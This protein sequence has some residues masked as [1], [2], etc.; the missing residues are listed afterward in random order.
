[1][2]WEHSSLVLGGP[3]IQRGAPWPV[4]ACF[5]SAFLIWQAAA[6]GWCGEFAF[7]HHFIDR[8]LPGASYGQSCLVD[9]DK[10][11]DLDFI[12]GGKDEQKSVYWFE[13]RAPGDWVRHLLGANHPSDVGGTALDVDGDGWFDHVAG[14]VWYRNTGKPRNEPFERIVFDAELTAVHDLVAAD[15]DGDGRPDIVTMSDKNNLRWYRVSA[16]P[17]QPW[18]RKDIAAGVHAGV[19][20]GDIDGDGDMDIARSN[21]WFENGDGQGLK[22]IEHAIPFGNPKPPYPLATRCRIVDINQDGH[23]DLVMTENEIRAGKIAWLENRGGQGLNWAVHELPVGDQAPRGAYHSL[24]VADFDLDG[25]LDIFTVEMEAIA[26][27]RQPRWFIWENVDS[28]GATFRER[29]ILDNGLGGHEAVVADVDGDGDLDI[30]SKLWRPR[31]DNANGG[32]NHADFVENLLVPE[33]KFCIDGISPPEGAREVSLDAAIQAHVSARFDPASITQDCVRLWQGSERVT[34]RITTDLGGV[35][36]ISPEAPLQPDSDY[37]VE[38][39]ATLKSA[40]GEPLQPFTSR[41]RTGQLL[42]RRAATLP[43][44]RKLKIDTVPGMTSLA[45]APDGSLYAAT[46]EGSLLRWVIDPATGKPAS[47]PRVVWQDKAARITAM[48]FDPDAARNRHLWVALDDNAGA[49]VCELRFSA[50]IV[51]LTLPEEAEGHALV[52]ECIT[53]LPVGDH[54]VSGLNFGA[55]GRLYFFCGAITMLGGPKQGA[56]ETPLSAA[57]LVADP[58]SF[59]QRPV[60]VN[61]DSPVRYDPYAKDAPVRLFATGIREAYDLCWHSNGQLYAGVNQNDTNEMSPANPARQLPAVPMRADEP[62]LRIAAEKYYGHPNP[63]RNEWV[64]MGGNP[65]PE[66]DPWETTNLPVGTQPEPGFDPGLLIYNLVRVNGQSADGCAE[67]RGAGPLK[68]RL[69]IAFY[70]SARTIHT[71]AFDSEGSRVVAEEPLS[72]VQ[73]APL[74]FGAPLDLVIDQAHSR[75]YVADFADTRRKDSAREGALWL[76]ELAEKGR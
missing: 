44:F 67:W 33:R 57:V 36:T 53:G 16:D 73:G 22:W 7:R 51:R 21:A 66:K 35:V 42:E 34:A 10:D 38:I 13:F 17:R 5:C 26:G 56:S 48:C 6:T 15:L 71:F 28:H 14:G 8:D 76:V 40:A 59:G 62:L 41:F 9:V 32:R 31:R 54:A 75:L 65:T 30:C 43:P 12:T 18:E 69:L 52:Q 1:M 61:T 25:D 45:L 11:G 47:S 72:D 58:R 24:A 2:N 49:A 29:V 4:T 20:V 63:A 46:W 64:L 37:R 74:R 70:T 39:T 23:D 68:G 60:N 19:A 55:E 50:R 3:I 27:A